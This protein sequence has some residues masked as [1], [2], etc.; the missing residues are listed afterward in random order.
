M[1]DM[2][3]DE[4]PPGLFSLQ[5]QIA[6]VEREIHFRERCYPR[7][8][9]ERKMAQATVDRELA[10]MQQVCRTLRALVNDGK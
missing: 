3:D 2:F 4:T 6:C 5:E 1:I 10:C 7:W 8:V 9:A